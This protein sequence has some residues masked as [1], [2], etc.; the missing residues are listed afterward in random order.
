MPQNK[1]DDFLS[2]LKN[3][4]QLT[5]EEI[6]VLGEWSNMANTIGSI[7][8]R[9]NILSLEKIELV[10]NMQESTHKEKLFGQIAV[11]NGF[12]TLEEVER[13]LVLQRYYLHLAFASESMLRGQID[14]ETMLDL[15][16]DFTMPACN[17]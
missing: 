15:V 7:A 10:L 13:L 6:P 8:L 1:L 5:D 4:R 16:R 17:A 2:F 14:F 3:R 12:L 11:E 9:S